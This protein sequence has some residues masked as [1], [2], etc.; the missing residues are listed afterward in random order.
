MRRFYCPNVPTVA[1]PVV[2]LD[3]AVSHHVLRVVGIAPHEQVVLFD[4][5]G[6]SCIATLQ[7]VVDGCAVMYWQADCTPVKAVLEVCLLV[8]LLRQQAFST[9]IR[10]A[11]EIGVQ[12]LIP[13]ACARSVAQGDKASRW[14]R[15]AKA[16]SGQSGRADIMDIT[17]VM[18][19]QKAV[20]AV[21]LVPQKYIL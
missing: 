15:I 19:P 5:R 16:A 10:M 4:G 8:A 9:V 13:V 14:Q 3:T 21:H 2:R 6:E 11:S 1:Q 18:S 12:K 17:A 20:E 7:E